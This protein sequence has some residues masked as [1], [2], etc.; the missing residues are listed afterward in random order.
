MSNHPHRAARHAHLPGHI[1]D[2]FAQ[3]IGAYIDSEPGAPLYHT[4]SA[5]ANA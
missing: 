4:R 3:A 1:R 5:T 2:S